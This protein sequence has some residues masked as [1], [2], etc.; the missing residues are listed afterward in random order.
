MSRENPAATSASSPSGE[1]PTVTRPRQPTS[2]SRRAARGSSSASA[3]VH[4]TR[5][6]P[7]AR[8]R[9]TAVVNSSPSGVTQARNPRS[10]AGSTP[11]P[12]SRSSTSASGPIQ[13]SP[14]DTTAAARRAL[15]ASAGGTGRTAR[16]PLR[17]A[18]STIR[19]TAR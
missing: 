2:A 6:M 1:M 10:L 16:T 15:P 13:V 7:A 11:S 14:A 8:S 19:S 4:E 18:A 5:A 9:D 3:G 12:P 17:R